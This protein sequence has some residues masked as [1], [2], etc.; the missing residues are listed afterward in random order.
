M[1]GLSWLLSGAEAP[2]A[3]VDD[4][5]DA[6]GE[7]LGGWGP[8]KRFSVH[9]CFHP[10]PRLLKPCLGRVLIWVLAIAVVSLS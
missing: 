5:G 9:V 3:R 8:E 10:C 4:D 2:I 7:E 1:I 6:G